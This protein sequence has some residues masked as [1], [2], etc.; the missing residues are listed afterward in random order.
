M[1]V[2]ILGL[3]LVLV[4]VAVTIMKDDHVAISRS[5]HENP[6]RQQSLWK[7]CTRTIL[8]DWL[9]IATAEPLSSF[10]SHSLL[11]MAWT[12]LPYSGFFFFVAT[13]SPARKP[14]P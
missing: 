2:H 12:A 9:V 5:P 1:G 11:P 14:M 7:F 4:R 13:R 3:G 6:S 8:I 10:T